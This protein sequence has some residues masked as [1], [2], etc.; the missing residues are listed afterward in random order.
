MIKSPQFGPS[1]TM[2]HVLVKT[3]SPQQIP[4]QRTLQEL[5][6]KR[7]SFNQARLLLGEVDFPHIVFDLIASKKGDFILSIS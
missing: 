2:V 5:L 3:T 6:I 1:R 7:H 4:I